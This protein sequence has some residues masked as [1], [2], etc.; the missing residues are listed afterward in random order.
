MRDMSTK[1]FI[2]LILLLLLQCSTYQ[3]VLSTHHSTREAL[4]IIIG[5]GGGGDDDAPSPDTSQNCPPPPPPP[6]PPPP[7]PMLRPSPPPPAPMLR[8]SP[9]PPAPMLRPSLPPPAPMQPPSPRPPTQTRLERARE[10]ILEFKKR[11]KYDP[12]NII[13]TW[14]PGRNV[15][16]YTGFKCVFLHE[17]QQGGVYAVLFNGYQF[18]GPNLGVDNFLDKLEDVSLIHANSNKFKGTINDLSHQTRL[19]EIDLSNNKYTGEF[20]KSI[21]SATNLIYLDIR[22]NQ[23]SGYVPPEIFIMNLLVLFV[24]DNNFEQ[25]L[26]DALGSTPAA[27]LTLDGNRFTGPIP[28]SIGNTS[29]TLLEVLFLNNT[30]SGC[31]PYEIGLLKHTRVFDVSRNYLT[32]P[33]PQSFACLAGMKYLVLSYNQFYGTVPEL[34]CKLPLL[35][36]LTLCNNYFTQ[37]GPECMKLVRSKVLDVSNNCILGLPNQRSPEECARFFNQPR[38]CPDSNMNFI[39]CKGKAAYLESNAVLESV[40]RFQSP[41]NY[42]ALSP[43]P[44]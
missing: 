6:C 32:G 16:D 41:V 2:S 23:L 19:Y 28:K 29:N 20:P 37:V 33:I 9:P 12:M 43:K 36:K 13:Q 17:F 26:P 3:I 24:N 31:L 35:M 5:G 40:P 42:P 18:D 34:V 27:F 38:T 21:F 25:K 30:L 14:Q 8:P 4:E 15:C 11:I 22:Y 10:V 44:N 39:P 7:A 1:S